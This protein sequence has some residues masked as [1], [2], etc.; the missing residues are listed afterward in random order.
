VALTLIFQKNLS[1]SRKLSVSGN[2][3]EIGRRLIHYGADVNVTTSYGYTPLHLAALWNAVDM[4]KL[5]IDKKADLNLPDVDPL[6]LP[7][8]QREGYIY[9]YIERIDI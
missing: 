9:I 4:G 2:F 5:L 8:L 7:L 3:V 1:D 6:P